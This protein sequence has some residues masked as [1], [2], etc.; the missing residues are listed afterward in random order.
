MSGALGPGLLLAAFAL[1]CRHGLDVDHLSAITDL[2]CTQ[3]TRRRSMVLAW[4]YAAG[5]AA[6]VLCFGVIAIALGSHLPGWV[7]DVTGRLVG[8]SLVALAIVTFVSILRQRR[9]FTPRSRWM[10]LL[11]GWRRLRHR[12]EPVETIVI[13][14]DHPHDHAH[15]HHGDVDHDLL[16]T[17]V[18]AG[19]G[20]VDADDADDA[21]DAVDRDAHGHALGPVHRHLHRHVVAVPADPLPTYS[22]RGALGLGVLHGVGAETPTQVLILVA[23]AGSDNAVTGL[24]ALVAFLVGLLVM[25]TVVAAGASV[26]FAGARRRRSLL[27]TVSAVVAAASFVVGLLFL[28]GNPPEFL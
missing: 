8:V 17:P 7:D 9:D 25:N 21:D 26:G 2:S 16:T 3:V 6:T 18:G 4:L 20:A 19:A 22:A 13:T 28:L 12:R 27:V 23:A 11:D 14:H 15:D 1:G 10:L 24:L 5:H